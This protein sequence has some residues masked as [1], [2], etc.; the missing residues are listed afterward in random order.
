MFKEFIHYITL[1]SRT[2]IGLRQ[3]AEIIDKYTS[4][5]PSI[6]DTIDHYIENKETGLAVDFL[7]EKGEK[8]KI[9][10]AAYWSNLYVVSKEHK[11]RDKSILIAGKISRT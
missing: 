2:R 10:D 1:P 5:D 11:M 7:I 9:S 6:R 4:E 3:C 8:L